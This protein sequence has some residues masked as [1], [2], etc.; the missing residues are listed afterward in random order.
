MLILLYHIIFSCR[1]AGGIM[2]YKRKDSDYYT[3]RHSCF[4]LQYHLVLVTKYRHPV[5]TGDL[6]QYLL[7]YTKDYFKERGFVI[8]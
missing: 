1:M 3:N 8:L 6:E 4:L 7:S 2:Y 5:I